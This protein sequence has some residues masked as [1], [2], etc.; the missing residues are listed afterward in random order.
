MKKHVPFLHFSFYSLLSF[1][2][3][4]IS[5]HTIPAVGQTNDTV[6]SVLKSV[7]PHI[8]IPGPTD[9]GTTTCPNSNFGNGTFDNWNGCYG[10]WVEGTYAPPCPQ[11]GIYDWTNIPN[12]GHFLIESPGMDPCITALNKVFPG[13]QHSAL[14]GNRTCSGGAGFVD[15]LIYPITYDPN[16]SFFI[17]R[18]AVVLADPNGNGHNDTNTKPRFTIKIIDHLTQAV[19][20]PVCGS[21]DLYPGDGVTIWNTGPNNY[22]WKDWSTIGLDLSQLNPPIETGQLLDVVFTVHGCPWSAHTG[23]AYISAVCEQM[24]VSMS[25]CSGQSTVVLNGPPGFATYTWIG[26]IGP[27]S[28]VYVGNPYTIYNANS[29]DKYRLDLVSFYNNCTVKQVMTT[30]TFTTVIPG[31]TSVVNCVGNPSSFTDISTT[32]NPS[33]PIVNRRWKFEATD[34]FGDLTTN[35]TITHTF[36]LGP[37]EVTVESHSLDGCVG[38]FTQ[39]INVGPPPTITNLTTGK[40]ICSEENA[41][42]SMDFSQ[43]GASATWTSVVTTGT[44][45]ITNNPTNQ[46][47]TLINDQIVNTGTIDA[48]A[49]YTITPKIGDCSGVPI[50]YLVTVHPTATIAPI[51]DQ[52]FCNGTVVPATPV[53]SP[54]GGT[55]FAWTN[56]DPSIGLPASGIGDISG[57]TATNN[58]IAPVIA[59][60]E[61]VPT[62]NN[63]EGTH[64]TYTITVNPTA[65]VV[66]ITNQTFCNGTVVP[67]TSVTSPVGGTTFAWTNSDPS[68][69]LPASGTGDIASFTAS[70]TGTVPVT[71][72]IEITPT[73]NSCEGTHLTYTITINPT[74][75]VNS[76]GNQVLCHNATTSAVVFSGNVPG[77]VFNW[78]NSDPTIGLAA[79]GTGD[80][81]AF[82]AANTGT[83]PITATIVVTPTFTNTAVTCTGTSTS[84]TITVNPIPTVNSV[85]NQVLCHNATTSAVAF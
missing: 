75:T 33:Q 74:P 76:V 23:Y 55:T 59:T 36:T 65:T 80:I 37:H 56:S 43:T 16:N 27:N 45:T 79:S 67:A 12:G 82:T 2:F 60:I 7:I 53:T 25:G 29:G 4:S 19:I 32:T 35:P 17:Y 78:T 38:T 1:L 9:Q 62:A 69:G 8:E 77:T 20:D 47:G 64:L 3:I 72:T 22:L 24:S 30:I 13:D 31:F 54:V 40:E 66:P 42:I 10:P 50:T 73:A 81:A 18:S 68:I 51:T 85:G 21:F 28:T 6:K 46:S 39:T 63:C 57:F 70:N 61:I 34:P 14:I 41:N 83:I 71:A 58:G 48:V 52:T 15:Q 11:P 84:F 44:A 49:T 26:P 5:L